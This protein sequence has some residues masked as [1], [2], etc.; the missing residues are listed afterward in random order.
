M[1]RERLNRILGAVPTHLIVIGLMAIWI[2]PTLGLF[3]TSLRPIQA[4]NNS[5]W[6]T[7]FTPAT[8]GNEYMQYCGECHGAAGR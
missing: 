3:I 8:V 7:V 2:I 5:G 4:V 1:S 6:W